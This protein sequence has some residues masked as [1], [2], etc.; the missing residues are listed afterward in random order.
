MDKSTDI[1][2]RASAPVLV[3][4]CL[5]AGPELAAASIHSACEL[6]VVSAESRPEFG[7]ASFEVVA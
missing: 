6:T 5:T 3:F 4:G 2:G 1:D 7:V